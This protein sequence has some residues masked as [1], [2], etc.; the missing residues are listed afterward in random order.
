MNNEWRLELNKLNSAAWSGIDVFPN[1]ASKLDS[2]IKRNTG[3]IKKLKQGITKDS[4]GSL[5]TDIG[6]VSLE[7]YL[8]EIISTTNESLLKNSGKTDD[9]IAAVEVISGLHQRFNSEFTIPLIESFLFVFESSTEEIDSE[10][11]RIAR[12]NVLKNSVRILIEL[13][14]T[15]ILPNVE[16]LNKS[17]LPSFIANRYAKKEPI[18]FVVL[19]E[20]LNYKFKEAFTTPVATLIAK[21]YPQLL[22]D[23]ETE[24]DS[25]I[26]NLN[27]KT[28]LRSLFKIYTDIVFQQVV[29]SNKKAVK[30][31]KEHQKAQ[32]RTGKESSEYLDSY[33]EVNPIFERF[34]AAAVGLAEVFDLT[35]PEIIDIEE[36]VQ[37]QQP[38]VILNEGKEG[39]QKIWENEE[40][41]RFYESLAD[42]SEV[43]S[44]FN[45]DTVPNPEDVN[46]FFTSL[47]TIE[48]AE[49][50]DEISRNYWA[51]N[52][53]NRATRK[54]LMRFFIECKDWSKIALYA[55][56]IANNAEY[57]E[58]VK[59]ELVNH[60]DTGL[61]F[62]IHNEKMNVKNII[63]FAEL[64][65]FMLVPGFMI[66]HKIR[67]LA[68]HIT[69]PNNIEILTALFENLGKFLINKPEFR[70]QMEK[71]MALIQE[72][73]KD[74]LLTISNKAALDNLIILIYPPKLNALNQEKLELTP[75]Q[76]FYKILIRRELGNVSLNTAY[77]LILKAS[78]KDEKIQKTLFSV[79]SKPEK[80]SY[81]SLPKLANMLTYLFKYYKPFT[82]RV[83][84]TLL[85]KIY[86]GVESGG[87]NL[88]M[89]RVA[90]V[91][92]LTEL[93]NTSFIKFD[94][95]LDTMY[96]ILR[97]GY[98]GGQPNPF[99]IN[100]GDLP[101]NYF[102]ISLISTI[103]LGMERKS[104]TATKKLNIFIQFF[105]YYILCKDQPLPKEV[106]FKTENV[107]ALFPDF[108]RS[109]N[110]QSSYENLTA[111]L[112]ELGINSTKS[113]EGNDNEGED[114]EEEEEDD[115]DEEG[116][117]EPAG[118][119]DEIEQDNQL[120]EDI[121]ALSLS[122]GSSSDFSSDSDNIS[123]DEV[124]EGEGEEE[125]EEE[126]DD[127]DEDDDED[128]DEDE[129]EDDDEDEDEDEDDEDDEDEEEDEDDD[130]D[131]DDFL[132]DREK[133]RKRIMEEFEK[134][135]QDDNE[136]KAQAA[137]DKQF[138]QMMD[139]SLGSIKNETV[140][141][142]S[143]PKHFSIQVSN[144]SPATNKPKGGKIPFTFLSR[145]GK[146]TQAHAINVPSDTKFATEILE[147]E[148]RLIEERQKIKSIVMNRNFD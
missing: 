103:L 62:Q 68:V 12:V 138:Q 77:K 14:L 101:D 8:S 135:L 85:D 29:D 19:R 32:I 44:Q 117:S 43:H 95:L 5:I 54:R 10:K 70:P 92:Y 66:F 136:L 120:A 137:L 121:D 23:G 22:S 72:K 76:H 110:W 112:K 35:P 93:Y 108:K 87:Y 88:N 56:F 1:K 125:E 46:A 86:V 147:E 134:K 15:G 145:S 146:K 6:E 58:E 36:V 140:P 79:F 52:L 2:S 33:N 27:L 89:A 34:S 133:E 107:F 71:M 132:I 26:V 3:F 69:V 73:K 13:Q 105:E 45:P 42:L 40:T 60:F 39:Q 47:E 119:L 63:F 127:D 99:F 28:L 17:K 37:E 142:V 38:S 144:S 59:N 74:H 131:D 96:K 118:I 128:E 94:V 91:K 24:F 65:K 4:K 115:E 114:E 78:W 148:Q 129:D 116:T 20:V 141:T 16:D 50:V 18:L 31:M 130:D 57:L 49:Q 82:V 80:V 75:E 55:R 48:T 61:K 139:E 11:D 143:I 113:M 64:V 104:E 126:E 30:L 98:P 7:K 106:S 25:L 41:R 122:D 83:V 100:E 53:D 21:R 84:D 109:T 67:S 97:F 124:D 123:A 111:L 51:Q 81:Q 102:R 90:Q 9:I